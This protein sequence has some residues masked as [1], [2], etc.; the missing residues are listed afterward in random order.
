MAVIHTPDGQW[1]V[2][3]AGRDAEDAAIM[4]DHFRATSIVL[5]IGS[6][7]HADHIGGM[8]D[9]INALPVRLYVGDTARTE[10]RSLSTT[11]LRRRIRQRRVRVQLPGADT[12]DVGEVR[13]ILLPQ[14]P[15]DVANENNNSIVVRLEYAGFSMLFPGDAEHEEQQWLLRFYPELLDVDV[16][17][18]AHHGADNGVSPGWLEAVSPDAV[19]MSAGV[20]A[21]Y[22]H[23]G[24]VAVAEYEAA[25]GGEVYCTNRQGDVTIDVSDAGN[26]DITTEV[27]STTSCAYDGTGRDGG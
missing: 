19:V 3:D 17:E 13:L 21:R 26:Y 8:P 2:L 22:G 11:M 12:I 14:L 5:A 20:N 16:L 15:K 24:A 4:V 6:H 27:E 9:L 7:R 23:P 18:A 10:F 1:I 25:V